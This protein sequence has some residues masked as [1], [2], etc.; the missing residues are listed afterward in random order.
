[1]RALGFI[2]RQYDT[3]NGELKAAAMD[4][5]TAAVVSLALSLTY[6][7]VVNFLGARY[8]K[9]T[10][11]ALGYIGF[12]GYLQW[13]NLTVAAFFAGLAGLFS[14]IAI[15]IASREK[16]PVA[17]KRSVL[18]TTGA[19]I[20]AIAGTTAGGLAVLQ[21]FT[22]SSFLESVTALGFIAVPAALRLTSPRAFSYR[23]PNPAAIVGATSS[24]EEAP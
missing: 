12:Q 18:K 17:F 23:C 11:E 3:D 1:M 22:L 15:M 5:V 6:I 8:P 19:L 20:V 9:G 7:E 13:E 2:R 16:R 21:Q 10:Q 4:A 24:I 14:H